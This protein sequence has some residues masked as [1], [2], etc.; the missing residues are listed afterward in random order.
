[1]ISHTPTK[2]EHEPSTPAI[3][4]AFLR[5]AALIALT[6]APLSASASLA[7][8]SPFLPPN[9]NQKPAAPIKAAIQP[10]GPVSRE[11]E[12][13][14]VI[15]MEGEYRFSVFNRKEQKAYWLYENQAEDGISVREF[16][17]DS[18]SVVVNLNGRAERINLA[19]ASDSPL[20]V[21]RSA[22]SQATSN[23]PALPQIKPPQLAR[24]NPN[25]SGN[26][27]RT[28]PPRRRVILPKQTSD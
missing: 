13:R 9:Y 12:F 10:Q 2:S 4:K 5:L 15:Q 22:P 19:T 24:P 8:K 7:D 6:A 23:R 26:T 3:R 16:D 1:M 17:P 14:G 21:T 18:S 11:I 20:P 28:V 25:N 27:R